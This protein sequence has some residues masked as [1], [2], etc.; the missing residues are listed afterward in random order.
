[1]IVLNLPNYFPFDGITSVTFITK[2][3]VDSIT[4]AI[5]VSTKLIAYSYS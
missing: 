5:F 3:Y 1:M 2:A 4:S